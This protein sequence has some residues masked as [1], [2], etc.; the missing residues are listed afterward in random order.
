[1]FLG[2]F[3]LESATIDKYVRQATTSLLVHGSNLCRSFM[4]RFKMS[5]TFGMVK[6]FS[7]GVLPE[8]LMATQGRGCLEYV[9]DLR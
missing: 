9:G 2:L 6:S 7:F 8:P 3:F 4:P 5:S 1:M